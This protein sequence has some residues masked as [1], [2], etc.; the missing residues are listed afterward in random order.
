MRFLTVAMAPLGSLVGGVLATY[1]GLRGTLLTIGVLALLLSGA[2]VLWSPVRRH[3]TL[4]AV[5]AE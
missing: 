5:A 3:R 4:P 2:A 1:I